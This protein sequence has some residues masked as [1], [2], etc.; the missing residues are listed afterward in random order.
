[1]QTSDSRSLSG[2]G[3]PRH[4]HHG[5]RVSH[6]SSETNLDERPLSGRPGDGAR[7]LR[8]PRQPKPA[9]RPHESD[10]D[11]KSQSS[12]SVFTALP[13]T[14][15]E[16]EPEKKSWFSS[17]FGDKAERMAGFTSV[18]FFGNIGS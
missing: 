18:M 17:A 1:M 15:D 5:V 14:Y 13:M 8:T 11:Q 2:D 7:E 3:L 12:S 10:Q 16:P 6:S 4:A 9:G